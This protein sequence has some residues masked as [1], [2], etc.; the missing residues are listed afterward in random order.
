MFG[1]GKKILKNEINFD[2]L[3]QIFVEQRFNQDE[4]P[5]E[6]LARFIEVR[7]RMEQH[8]DEEQKEYNKQHPI[9]IPQVV[10][11]RQRLGDSSLR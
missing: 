3:A 2:N 10:P 11:T 8:F 7:L 1:T 6:F 9:S 5:E 4:T